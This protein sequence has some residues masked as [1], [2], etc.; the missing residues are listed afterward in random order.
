MGE[1]VRFPPEIILAKGKIDMPGIVPVG[2]SQVNFC[3]TLRSSEFL[4]EPDVFS[5]LGLVEDDKGLIARPGLAFR[6]TGIPADSNSRVCFLT[7]WILGFQQIPPADLQKGRVDFGFSF[8]MIALVVEFGIG[9]MDSFFALGEKFLIAEIQHPLQ[10]FEKSVD[11]LEL[12][13]LQE[14][15]W[16]WMG[17]VSVG[18]TRASTNDGLS[19]HRIENQ[20]ADFPL[21]K[22][23]VFWR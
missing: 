13:P 20:V 7:T 21:W 1:A 19:V 14:L 4:L 10:G 18:T 8:V 5:L 15:E 9:Q 22:E 6:C 3:Q 11:G 2:F 16:G 23:D 17:F 12:F